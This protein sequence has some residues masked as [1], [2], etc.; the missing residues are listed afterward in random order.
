MVCRMQKPHTRSSQLTLTLARGHINEFGRFH[1]FGVSDSLLR[2]LQKNRRQVGPEETWEGWH[3]ERVPWGSHLPGG[4]GGR[5]NWSGLTGFGAVVCAVAGDMSIQITWFRCY[6]PTHMT[7]SKSLSMLR[8]QLHRTKSSRSVPGRGEEGY[9]AGST[10]CP[11][12][13][14]AA[15][16]RGPGRADEEVT[17]LLARACAGS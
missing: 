12:P 1:G 13:T 16:A 2:R 7:L 14:M 9:G 8:T 10:S 5:D 6:F 17:G 3:E 15:R 11:T 4:Q